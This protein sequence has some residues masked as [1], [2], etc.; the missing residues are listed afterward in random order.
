V[1]TAGGLRRPG[2]Q[3]WLAFG[4]AGDRTNDILHGLGYL[5]ARGSDHVA[6]SELRPYLRGRDADDIVERMRAGAID[7]G[8]TEVSVFPD[9]VHSLTSMLRESSP[10]DV[11]AVTALGQ[12]PEVFAC[13]TN[14]ARSGSRPAGSDSWFAGPAA[15]ARNHPDLAG[16][17]RPPSPSHRR[18]KQTEGRSRP[19]GRGRDASRWG[20]RILDRGRVGGGGVR[21][22]LELR[23][24]G[25]G[26]QARAVAPGVAASPGV[27]EHDGSTG[28]GSFAAPAGALPE[29]GARVVKTASVTLQVKDGTFDDW[30]QQATMVASRHGGYVA[31]SDTAEGKLRSGTLVIRVPASEFE[32]TLAELKGLGTVRQERLSGQDVTSQFVD[33]DA[34][35][36]NWQAQES[37][38]LGLMAKATNIADSIRVQ[39]QLQD[40]QLQIEELKGQ[41]RVLSDQADLSTIT[42]AVSEKGFVVP[43]PPS[44]TRW[45]ERGTPP[46]T[47][48][49]GVLAAVVVGLGYLI[50]ISA[51]LLL[52]AVG[53]RV[54]RPRIRAEARPQEG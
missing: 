38:L 51:L 50:P 35:L 2:A 6:I 22:R 8:A 29:V 23:F 15:N 20:W 42:L 3:V 9:E 27:T 33:L 49:S 41:L 45:P 12:R 46:F 14:E 31:S 36:R 43:E 25:G 39:N 4:S 34:R 10:G 11:V 18:T 5:A 28:G 16:T 52:V 21:R 47:A 48:S 26:A 40:V 54:L 53:V 19:C 7:G 44:P 32:S 30:F 1:E 24:D 17:L 37:V 13:S